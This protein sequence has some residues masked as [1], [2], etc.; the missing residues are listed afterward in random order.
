MTM[1]HLARWQWLVVV[2]SVAVAACSMRERNWD[3][4]DNY[5]GGPGNF[6]CRTGGEICEFS[7]EHQGGVCRPVTTGASLDASNGGDAG[8]PR[9]AITID[10]GTGKPCTDPSKPVCASGKCAPCSAEERFCMGRPNTPFCGP[11]GACVACMTNGDCKTATTPICSADGTCVACTAE[12][13]MKCPA[14][15][16]L[17]DMEGRCVECIGHGDCKVD[18]TKPICHQGS[19]TKCN[20][21]V[22]ALSCG[23]GLPAVCAPTGACVDCVDSKRDC[24]DTKPICGPDNKC[25]TCATDAECVSRDGANPGVCMSHDDGRCA[26][27]A[28]TVYVQ[29]D[30]PNCAGDG[31]AKLPFCNPQ[32][33]MKVL[34]DVRRV[35]VLRGP[36]DLSAWMAD[37]KGAK[38]ISV[39]GQN[40]ARVN[41]GS[42]G[43]K[44]HSGHHYLRGL[45]FHR[46]S[47]TGLTTGPDSN[48]TLDRCTIV[49]NLRGGLDLGGAF[50]ITNTLIAN[51]GALTDPAPSG[52]VLVQNPTAGRKRVFR[53]NTVSENEAAAIHCTHESFPID[54]SIIRVRTTVP[55]ISRDLMVTGK[56][57]LDDTNTCCRGDAAGLNP[58]TFR[59]MAGSPCIDKVQPAMST[60]FDIDGD[61]RPQ[62]NNLSDCGA[63]E[64]M[65]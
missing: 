26:T 48:V 40:G 5:D 7:P 22:S 19:C 9:D 13:K 10:C 58:T 49:D 42:N 57:K 39:I 25:R 61:P 35:M 14:G 1:D 31:T 37:T 52:G 44:L 27:D 28:E 55:P 56:C 18:P 41:V 4:C 51:N 3:A 36:Q 63:D 24:L 2:A 20:A 6:R 23:A 60:L 65:K 64:F 32:E 46:G 29:A 33:A 16:Q 38:P 54:A 15:K 47:L 11:A 30:T 8:A 45:T 62:G 21:M 53:H 12:T 50:E 34:T 43:V 59:L 17:C